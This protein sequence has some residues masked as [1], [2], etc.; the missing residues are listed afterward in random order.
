MIVSSRITLETLVGNVKNGIINTRVTLVLNDL[1]KEIIESDN[2]K[3]LKY[4]NERISK[5]YSNIKVSDLF[6]HYMD[7]YNIKIFKLFETLGYV[8]NKEVFNDLNF[9]IFNLLE[10][11]DPEDIS[12]SLN[13]SAHMVLI[14]NEEIGYLV[15]DENCGEDDLA[16]F[17]FIN[18]EVAK[19][20]F[21]LYFGNGKFELE[22]PRPPGV[23]DKIMSSEIVPKP[24]DVNAILSYYTSLEDVI[25][26]RC[27]RLFE[28]NSKVGNNN[29]KN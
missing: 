26:D 24:F 21:E 2:N 16:N 27:I 1:D 13:I 19:K 7:S 8:P 10:L 6:E 3:I 5:R 25:F 15:S 4:D 22:L 11:E 12:R 9:K 14:N 20:Y 28:Y 17:Y 18:E 23:S 29:A